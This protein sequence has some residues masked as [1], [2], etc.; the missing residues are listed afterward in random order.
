MRFL[1]QAIPPQVQRSIARAV[2]AEVRDWVVRRSFCGG[3]DWTRTHGFALPSSGEGYL[4]LNLAGREA[5][6]SLEA[7]GDEYRSRLREGILSFKDTATGEPIA[8]DVVFTAGMYPGTRSGL[9]PDAVILWNDLP[10]ATEIVSEKLGRI[11][12]KLATG[13]TGEHHP[14]GF[15]VLAGDTRGLGTVPPLEQAA[16]FAQFA[17][18][19]LLAESAT[20]GDAWKQ[21]GRTM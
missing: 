19:V 5:Q 11:T 7:P 13:R 14:E 10:P 12:A 4:R 20:R 17:R 9:L 6:G 18:A 21:A 3:L 8:K 15:A 1:R 16:D 2:P